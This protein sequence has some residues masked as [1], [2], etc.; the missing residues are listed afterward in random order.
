MKA[1]TEPIN[2]DTDLKPGAKYYVQ[3]KLDGIRIKFHNGVPYTNTGKRIP[4]RHIDSALRER[5]KGLGC[6]LN[7]DGELMIYNPHTTEPLSFNDIQS[8]VMSKQSDE[9][10]VES[11]WAFLVF[12][13]DDGA[14]MQPYYSRLETLRMGLDSLTD[15]GYPIRML[16]YHT[17]EPISFECK[18]AI[19]EVCIFLITHGY[20]GAMLKRWDGQY[21]YGRLPASTDIVRKYVEWVREEAV[22]VGCIE[23]Q[24]NLDTT[25]RQ[26]DAMMPAGY[27]GAFLVRH[28]RFGQFQIGSGFNSLQRDTYWRLRGSGLIGRSVTFKYRPDHMKDAPCPAIFIGLRGEEDISK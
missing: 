20:E 28:P 12:D 3:P 9:G 23:A 27:L 26:K 24:T 11:N 19:K 25:T 4:N 1:P 5:Y 17:M 18:E 13:Y 21:R 16:P 14:K 7:L 15:Y 8:V 2:L 10:D 22:I 6:T